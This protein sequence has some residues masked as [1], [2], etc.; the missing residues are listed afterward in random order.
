MNWPNFIARL[1]LLPKLFNN[2]CFV[3]HAW[4]LDDAMIF[5]CLKS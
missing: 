2:K 5:E 4:V 3:F 1:C